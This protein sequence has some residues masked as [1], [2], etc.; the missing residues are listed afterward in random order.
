MREKSNRPQRSR[1]HWW[2]ARL[3]LILE[4]YDKSEQGAGQTWE[5]IRQND[6]SNYG[7]TEKI[8][9]KKIPPKE[10]KYQ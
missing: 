3:Y 1:T 9:T 10:K 7:N 2:H 5:T 8:S 6:L 4:M